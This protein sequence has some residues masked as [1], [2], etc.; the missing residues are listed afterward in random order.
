MKAGSKRA[1]SKEHSLSRLDPSKSTFPFLV[2]NIE[3]SRTGLIAKDVVRRH[4]TYLKTME[5]RI[6][7]EYEELRHRA[8]FLSQIC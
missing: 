5:T 1:N 4:V 3:G 2:T 6:E 8:V 7:R